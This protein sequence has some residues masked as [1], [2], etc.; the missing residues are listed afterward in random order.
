MTVLTVSG[1]RQE[2]NQPFASVFVLPNCAGTHQVHLGSDARGT[3]VSAEPTGVIG[4]LQ[5]ALRTQGCRWSKD[6]ADVGTPKVCDV[7]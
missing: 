6:D 3:R 2:L 1:S 5:E 4:V 7:T